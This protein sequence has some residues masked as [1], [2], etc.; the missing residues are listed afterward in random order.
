MLRA[1]PG[2]PPDPLDLPAGCRF[3]PRCRYARDRCRQESPAL[4]T[5]D[6]DDGDGHAYRCFYPVG[7]GPR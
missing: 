4:V 6:G 2:R 3:A 7:T 1:N 5:E